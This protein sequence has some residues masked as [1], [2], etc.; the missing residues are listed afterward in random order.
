MHVFVISLYVYTFSCIFS[1]WLFSNAHSAWTFK[2]N[3]SPVRPTCGILMFIT[4]VHLTGGPQP[5]S[6][7]DQRVLYITIFV[8]PMVQAWDKCIHYYHESCHEKSII[9]LSWKH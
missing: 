1:L 2:T 8:W 3:V 5:L 9:Y 6:D 7:V 4:A